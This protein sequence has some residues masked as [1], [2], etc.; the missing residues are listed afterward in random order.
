MDIELKLT[1]EIDGS[2]LPI[3]PPVPQDPVKFGPSWWD[4]AFTHNPDAKF[5]FVD[6]DYKF[7]KLLNLLEAKNAERC[8][9]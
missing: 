4:A 9:T 8:K 3:E 5:A 7:N 6:M 2:D 1:P